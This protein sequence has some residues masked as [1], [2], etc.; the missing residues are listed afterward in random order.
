[1]YEKH[2]NGCHVTFRPTLK[3]IRKNIFFMIFRAKYL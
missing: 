3:E 2:D 1:M